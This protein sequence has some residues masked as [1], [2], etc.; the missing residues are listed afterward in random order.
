MGTSAILTAPLTRPVSERRMGMHSTMSTFASWTAALAVLLISLGLG[1]WLLGT[2]RNVRSTP[3]AHPAAPPGALT[4]RPGHDDSASTGG[5]RPPIRPHERLA[6]RQ[7]MVRDQ[8]RARGVKDERVLAAMT[9]VPR[10]L[11]VPER[12][13]VYA[14]ADR[15]LPIGQGQTISQPYI[16]ALMTALLE[17]EP[18]HTVLEIGT[19]SGYQAAVLAALAREVYTIEIIPELGEWGRDNLERLGHDNVHARIG[20]GYKGW[21]D[22]APFDG[23]ILTAAPPRIP[24]PLIDQLAVGGRLVAPVGD[25]G[26]QELVLIVKTE[27]G[28]VRQ[29]VTHVRFVPM[30]GEAQK[31][32]EKKE[33]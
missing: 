23:I 7:V 33:D 13:A 32:K 3:G 24:Q 2:P 30:V 31:K 26:N 25:R 29:Y 21:P 6:E 20:D 22:H 28:V 4:L 12:V 11:F 1:V 15:P 17:I 18:G 14:Y 10:H 27:S 9:L 5:S 16:V 19:G 8:I